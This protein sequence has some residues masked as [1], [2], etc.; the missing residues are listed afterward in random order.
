MT[1]TIRYAWGQSSLGDFVAAA[2]ER[3]IVMVEFGLPGSTAIDD[4]R[5]RLPGAKVVEDPVFMHETLDRLG[6]LIDHPERQCSLALDMRGSDFQCRVW[7]AVREIRAGQTATYGDIAQRLG[8]PR[9]AR[10]VAGACAAN[11]MAVVIPCHRVVKKG[12]AIADFRW[13]FRRK[14]A[15]LEREQSTEFQLA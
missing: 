10:E 12:G 6:D 14:R 9:E 7:N 3:G 11:T 13:G 8:I 4:L 1:E 5:N 2:S 15:L